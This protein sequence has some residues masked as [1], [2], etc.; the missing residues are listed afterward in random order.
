ML[1]PTLW[2]RGL[3]CLPRRA[4]LSLGCG[5]EGAGSTVTAHRGVFPEAGCQLPRR[6]SERAPGYPNAVW[7]WLATA[8]SL[9]PGPHGTHPSPP[10]H[11]E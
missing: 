1:L 2:H 5:G 7:E 8:G 9:P 6:C 10:Q 3:G 11:P 4:P